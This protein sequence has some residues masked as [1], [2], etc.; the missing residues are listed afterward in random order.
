MLLMDPHEGKSLEIDTGS[1]KRLNST[2]IMK[3]EM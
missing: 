1:Q 2:K 3:L